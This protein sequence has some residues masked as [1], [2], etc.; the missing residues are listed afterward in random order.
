MRI[1]IKE[2]ELGP[3]QLAGKIQPEAL[4]LSP[5][6][7]MFSG[8]IQVR[9]MAER[10]NLGIRVRGDFAA[11]GKVP[12][13]RCLEPFE[14][15]LSPAFELYYQQNDARHPITG[16][17]ELGEKD[18]EVSFFS[19]DGID[20]TDIVRE[21]IFLSLPMKPVCRE[22]CRGLCPNCGGNRN[23]QSCNCDAVLRDPR[24]QPLLKI[25]NRMNLPNS[26][27]D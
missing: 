13:A 17:I 26:G 16:E 25:K 5:D 12:C 9:V 10:H 23:M 27:S 15:V 3:V 8:P 4:Q 6:E 7:V 22:E 20:V 11:L 1:T 14:I 18:T 21:Q 2:L 24:L 19:G